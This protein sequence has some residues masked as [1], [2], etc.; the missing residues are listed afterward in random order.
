MAEASIG[1][2]C[3]L[4][5][6]PPELGGTEDRFPLFDDDDVNYNED[7]RE[8]TVDEERKYN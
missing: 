1:V 5:M 7:D 4:R 6:P 3:P 8:G 2:R